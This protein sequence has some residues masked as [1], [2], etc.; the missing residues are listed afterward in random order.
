MA[1]LQTIRDGIAAIDVARAAALFDAEGCISIQR[2]RRKHGDIFTLRAYVHMRDPEWT[3][4]LH[5]RW[6]GGLGRTSRNGN[7]AEGWR[8][9]VSSQGA[10]RFLADIAPFVL[11]ERRRAA[12]RVA[13]AFQGQK[14]GQGTVPWKRRAAYLDRQVEFFLLMKRLNLK[15]EE[16]LTGS[17][18]TAAIA[19][20]VGGG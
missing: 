19:Q 6:G 2:H 10:A 4:F 14:L 7:A 8:W 13:L 20:V 16:R 3:Q 18:R 17:E 11:T 9:S 1:D 5:E 12:L 15:G